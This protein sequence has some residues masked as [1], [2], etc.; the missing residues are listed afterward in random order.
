MWPVAARQTAQA[1]E[2]LPEGG[3]DLDFLAI[4]LLGSFQSNA[5]GVSGG[6]FDGRGRT[7]LEPGWSIGSPFG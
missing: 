1:G 3:L 4:T 6:H 5:A 2:L 7:E